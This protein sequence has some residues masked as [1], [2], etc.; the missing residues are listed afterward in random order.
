MKNLSKIIIAYLHKNAVGLRN[1]LEQIIGGPLDRRQ[2]V[3]ELRRRHSVA[4][5]DDAPGEHCGG[6]GHGKIELDV[7]AGVVVAAGEVCA[8]CPA[9]AEARVIAPRHPLVRRQVAGA[10][11]LEEEDRLRQCIDVVV[12][13]SREEWE[14]R[15]EK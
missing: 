8:D 14:L 10:L 15:E 2:R 13:A 3:A 4:E 6:E 5:L 1:R 12:V 7:V 11:P 9:V